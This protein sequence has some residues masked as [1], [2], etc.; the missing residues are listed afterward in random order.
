LASQ[1]GCPV[2][3]HAVTAPLSQIMPLDGVW[4]GPRQ[5][6]PVQQPPP[7]HVLLGQ[8]PCPAAPQEIHDPPLH[9]PPCEHVEPSAM[10]WRVPVSQQPLEQLSPAQHGWPGMPQAAHRP[11]LH[12]SCELHVLPAQHASPAPPQVTHMLVLLQVTPEAVQP[13]PPP[14]QASPAPP[15][16]PQL[17]FMHIALTVGQVVPEP[18]QTL[19]TQQPPPL[20]ALSAQ[21]GWPG[22]P[23]VAQMPAPPPAPLH[24][25]VGSPHVRPA[26]HAWP[27]AP[28]S[29][30]TPPT[31]LPALQVLPAQH[32]VP[33]AP[34]PDMSPLP[35]SPMF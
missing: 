1:H 35:P 32:E 30:H 5:L 24:T 19:A 3:P 25:S 11:P 20:H 17:P 16:V 21:H 10:H 31:Q 26:Q 14:Q 9:A 23:Q 7:V 28:Q 18:T 27:A 4:P 22:P 33:S 13:T 34:Q 2:S 29:R 12:A 8:Q 15:Q 6:V